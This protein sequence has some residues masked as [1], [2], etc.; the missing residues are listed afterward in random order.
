MK[1]AIFLDR[2]G[3]INVEKN[4][5]YKPE[6]FEFIDGIFEALRAF[7]KLGYI[8]VVVT[9]QS[10]IGR[11][12]YSLEEFHSLTLWMV[13]QFAK[14]NVEIAKVNFCPHSPEQIC[15]CRKPSPKMILDAAAE[16]N[17]DLS[18]SWMIG[19]K[20][21]D[22]QSALDA[23]ISKNQTIQV[24]SGHKFDETKSNAYYVLDSIYDAKCI[25]VK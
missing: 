20:F 23:G 11:G 12:Y 17:I 2:D 22:I 4:Y 14:N 3:V 24:R 16:L 18:N 5:L 7:A 21:I 6:D 13:E 1:K 15:D 8:F 19:D 9:N 25:I 10:G